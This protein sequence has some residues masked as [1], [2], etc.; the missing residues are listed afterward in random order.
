MFFGNAGGDIAGT[1]IA[2][3]GKPLEI[4]G[5]AVIRRSRPTVE[6]PAGLLF[7]K[8]YKPQ[9]ETYREIMG[10]LA[11]APAVGD[12]ATASGHGR[13]DKPERASDAASGK[14]RRGSDKSRWYMI[15]L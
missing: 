7:S 10:A 4:S 13:S 12:T 5:S 15:W 6:V 11:E 3:G 2:L 1:V 8:T 9:Q 14:A